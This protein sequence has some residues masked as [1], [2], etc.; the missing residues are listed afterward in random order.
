MNP[1]KYKASDFNKSK[2]KTANEIWQYDIDKI[3]LAES[4]RYKVLTIWE[5]EYHQ[6]PK[7]T[8]QKCIQFLKNK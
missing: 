2:Q 3:K 5:S 7:E 8:I 1:N 4:H 6:N